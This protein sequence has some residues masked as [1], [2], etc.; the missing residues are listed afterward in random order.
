MLGILIPL[1]YIQKELH[2]KIK[3]LLMILIMIGLNFLCEKKYFKKTEKKNNIYI[4]A[5]CYEISWFCQFTFYIKNLK[6]DGF[7]AFNW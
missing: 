5:F 6:I 1:K 2:G 3:I 4:N 7:V